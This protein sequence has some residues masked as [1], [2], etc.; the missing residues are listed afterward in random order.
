MDWHT[1]VVEHWPIKFVSLVLILAYVIDAKILKVPNWI[2]FPLAF[3]GL[4]YHGCVDGWTGLGFA[5][6][7]L[8]FGLLTLLPL[9]M[10]GGM[11]EGDVKLMAG[12]GA[13]VGA[14]LVIDA[15]IAIALVGGL[16]AV[17]MIAVSGR[18]R[19]HLKMAGVI[20]NDIWTL[21]DPYK[22]YDRAR[23]RKPSMT[24]LPYGIPV[25]IGAI[26]SFQAHGV[27]F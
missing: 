3:S 23:E 14:I 8:C 5:F 2:T 17:V 16:M 1:L 20:L 13:W 21:K 6:V 7:G 18:W 25:C 22:I 27:L 9:H 15:F 26:A 19:H 11:G 4:I 24:L 12:M 10:V